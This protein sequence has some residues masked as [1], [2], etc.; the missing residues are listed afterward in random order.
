MVSMPCHD[1]CPQRGKM[2]TLSRC[3]V[4]AKGL[5]PSPITSISVLFPAYETVQRWKQIADHPVKTLKW[6]PTSSGVSPSLSQI[7]LI[8]IT[9][10]LFFFLRNKGSEVYALCVVLVFCLTCCFWITAKSDLSTILKLH[11]MW[12]PLG[13]PQSQRWTTFRT[14]FKNNWMVWKSWVQTFLL[15][16]NTWLNSSFDVWHVQKT[17]FRRVDN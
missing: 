6:L 3:D 8:W 14:G 16:K 2:V 9:N 15:Y 5:S 7:S 17:T 4:I 12:L 1:Q 10:L 13:A 11:A